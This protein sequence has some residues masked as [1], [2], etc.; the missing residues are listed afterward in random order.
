MQCSV[1]P[2]EAESTGLGGFL[3]E[4]VWPWP[5]RDRLREGMKECK[6]RRTA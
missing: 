1:S 4:V 6:L 5:L 3:Q 2:G